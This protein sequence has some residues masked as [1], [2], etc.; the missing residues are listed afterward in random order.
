M[1]AGR[2]KIKDKRQQLLEERSR[3]I[4]VMFR[5]AAIAMI[6]SELTG[7]LTVLIDGIVTSRFLGVDV[8][9]AITLLK[10]FTSIVLMIAG[11]FSTGCNIVCSQLIGACEKEKVNEAFNLTV[12]LSLLFGAVVIA[13]CLLF[14]TGVLTDSGVALDRYPVLN[15]HLYDYMRGYLI[16]IPCM[17]LFQV[18][19]PLVVMDGGKSLYPLSCAALCVTDIVGDLLNLFVFHGGAFGMGLATSASYIVGLIV[20]LPH[21]RRK[22]SF[23]RLSLKKTRFSCLRE[24]ARNGSP[25]LVKRLGGTLRDIL[26][27]YLNMVVALS[28]AAIAARGIQNDLFTFLFCIPSGLGATLL[29]MVGI[30]YSANDLQGLKR[31]YIYA[32][33]YGFMLSAAAGL[34]TFLLAP[35]LTAIYTSD[36]EVTSLAIFSIR[37][38]SV[39]LVFDTA[40][41]LI[42]HYFQGIGDMKKANRLSLCE[43]FVIPVACAFL[44]GTLYGS[45]GIL[46]SAAISKMV[47]MLIVF[48][49]NCI[50]NRGIPKNWADIMFLPKDFGGSETDNIYAEI[51]TMDDVL[52]ASHDSQV[53]CLQH[54]ASPRQ[55]MLIALFVEEMTENV[56]QH[57]EKMKLKPPVV[58]F[59]LYVN[60]EGKFCF[61]LMDLSEHFDPTMY[62]ELHRGDGPEDHI[63]IRMVT[64]MAAD[65]RYFS[66]FSSNNL[67]VY[68]DR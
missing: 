11:F 68:L 34:I 67:V 40:S 16:S 65:I 66:T 49:S 24:I 20:L 4:C 15:V 17:I 54:G 41:A 43:R 18:L 35:Q 37:W 60:K 44:F 59:R 58:D 55:A 53:F 29:T 7:V 23:F 50:Y 8:Y 48:I 62:Y 61:S 1:N 30:H 9:S 42:Q 22:S 39:A 38:M 27:N 36:P 13:V 46:M 19:G 25:S 33:R 14:P 12:R 6:L 56:I 31:L 21:F 32:H 52:R 26:I 5:T 64:D 10:P 57:A 51:R 3:N 2:M 45:R 28:A 63:G 47:P